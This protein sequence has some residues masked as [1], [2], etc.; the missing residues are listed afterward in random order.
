MSGGGGSS[1][2]TVN[3]IPAELAPLAKAYA[4]QAMQLGNNPYQ[5]YTGQRFAGMNDSQQQAGNFFQQ[6]M[7]QGTNPYLD[8]MVGKAQRNTINNYNNVIRPG[9]DAMSARSGSFGNSGV[10]Q[11]AQMQQD[12]LGSQL[13]DIATSMYGGQYNNDQ[14][15]RQQSANSFMNYGNLQQ[16]NAQQPYDFAYQQFQEAQNQ[17]Y[18]NL[19]AMG[20]PF[21]QNMGGSQSTTSSQRN[22][23]MQSLLGTALLAGSFFS[24]RRLKEDIKKVGETN[25]GLPIYTYKYKGD[26]ATQ[27]GVMAQEV[28]KKNPEAVT[29]IAG[30]LAVDYSKVS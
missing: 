1:Q 19:G 21:G 2:Q 23:P 9:I 27:M 28:Q 20:A 8:Q 18:K 17:P 3:N 12:Q 5:A 13:G 22:D 26:N 14:A 25:D 10:A 4:G 15:F 30:L 24:D 16:A 29:N 7:S 6:G 11:T